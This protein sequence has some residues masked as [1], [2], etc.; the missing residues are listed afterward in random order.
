MY[1]VEKLRRHL[2]IYLSLIKLAVKEQQEE[3]D[4]GRR[5]SQHTEEARDKDGGGL[6]RKAALAT[7]RY[8]EGDWKV[9]VPCSIVPERK[10]DFDHGR[11]KSRRPTL[12]VPFPYMSLCGQELDG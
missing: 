4:F 10:R 2:S 7:N 12:C 9:R 6:R 1:R 5:C 8:S 11:L 3:K